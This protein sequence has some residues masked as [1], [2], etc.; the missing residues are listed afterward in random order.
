M[1][2]IEVLNI[3]KDNIMANLNNIRRTTHNRGS[4][5]TSMH[6]QIADHRR[7]TTNQLLDET[8]AL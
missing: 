8:M 2:F 6:S 7:L 1:I 3:V 5:P 4:F